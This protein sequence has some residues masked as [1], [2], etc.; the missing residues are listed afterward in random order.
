MNIKLSGVQLALMTAMVSGV[1][2]FANKFAVGLVKPPVLFTGLKN[3]LVGLALLSLLLI[4]KKLPLLKQLNKKQWFQLVLI[5]VVGGYVP[6]YL[7]FTGLASAGAVSAGIIHK[8]LVFWVALLAIPFLKERMS[9]VKLAGVMVLFYANA[10]VGGFNG[11]SYSTGELM[12]LGATMLWAIENVVAKKALETIDPDLVTFGRMG[13]GSMLLLVTAHFST[14]AGVGAV[15][16][17]TLLQWGVI[18]AAALTLLAYVS[19]WYRAL[20]KLG[21]ISVTALLVTATLIT[22]VLNAIFVTH[23]WNVQGTTQVALMVFGAWL[24]LKDTKSDNYSAA[25]N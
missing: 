22:N 9:I 24:Y 21:A 12:I 14:P 15:A 19:F 10:M 18:G 7:F 23:N 25:I 17:L 2:I 6:F 8:T 11:F 13:I 16:S 3:V 20:A 1:S 4:T 5:G